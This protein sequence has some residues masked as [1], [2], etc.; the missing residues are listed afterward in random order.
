[1]KESFLIYKSLYGPLKTLS[2][3]EK[4]LLFEAIFT[5]QIEGVVPDLPPVINMAFQF[6]KDQFDRDDNKYNEICER[7]HRNGSKGGRPGDETNNPENPAKHNEPAGLK[8]THPNPTNPFNPTK[9]NKPTGLKLTQPYPKNPTKPDTDTDTETEAD[10][11]TEAGTENDKKTIKAFKDFYSCYP[12]TKRSPGTEYENF[13]KQNRNIKYKIIH[14]L[15][16]ALEKEKQFRIK[17]FEL[18]GWV[19]AWKNLST[20]IREKCWEQEFSELK[21]AIHLNGKSQTVNEVAL[22]T[23]DKW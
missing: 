7:N 9:P 4:G 5:Y 23:P 12:G 10:T 17:R 19:P 20:W 2:L 14:L 11:D 1:M 22:K 15:L 8:S 13:T 21:P 16:P 18:N 6:V 3:E